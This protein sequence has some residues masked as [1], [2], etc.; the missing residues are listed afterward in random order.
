MSLKLADTSGSA[1]M[2]WGIAMFVGPAILASVYYI[3]HG[4]KVYAGPVS[5]VKHE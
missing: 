2:N 4:R 1:S 5:R 3:V